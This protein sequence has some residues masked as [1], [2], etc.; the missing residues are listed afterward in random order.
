MKKVLLTCIGLITGFALSAQILEPVKLSYG[1]KKIS[2]GTYEVTITASIQDG[3]HIYSQTTP[4]GGPLPTTISFNDNPA[5]ILQDDIKEKGQLEKKYEE[6]FG[7]DVKYYSDKV[8]FVQTVKLNNAFAA[9]LS[10][11]IEY[12]ACDDERCLPPEEVEFR[13]PVK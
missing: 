8:D 12:M 7:V 4:D 5:V 2:E 1:A 3:W 9:N 6:V 13:I 11:T 10:G